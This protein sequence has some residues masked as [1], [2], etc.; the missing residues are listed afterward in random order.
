MFHHHNH[1]HKHHSP[2]PPLSNPHTF[3][4]NNP[5]KESTKLVYSHKPVNSCS[6]ERLLEASYRRRLRRRSCCLSTITLFPHPISNRRHSPAATTPLLHPLDRSAIYRS[7]FDLFKDEYIRYE[8]EPVS[9]HF[10][11]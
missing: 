5:F 10:V 8:D 6:G 1:C 9:Y 2:P 7:G 4:S 11:I 3:R